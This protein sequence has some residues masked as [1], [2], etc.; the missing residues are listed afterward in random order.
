MFVSLV[1]ASFAKE[2]FLTG[3]AIVGYLLTQINKSVNC[4]D[5]IYFI[6]LWRHY[7]MSATGVEEP[8][9]RNSIGPR[10]ISPDNF[11]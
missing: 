3:F 8:S 7:I 10:L 1:I 2:L 5:V 11:L 4:V 9:G 6:R